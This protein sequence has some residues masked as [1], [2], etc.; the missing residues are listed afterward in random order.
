MDITTTIPTKGM[1]LSGNPQHGLHGWLHQCL[2]TLKADL[3]SEF[4]C[5]RLNYMDDN[6]FDT[7][8]SSDRAQMSSPA[9]VHL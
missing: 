2:L 1:M 7:V 8:S 4:V 5:R 6:G 9:R 3:V